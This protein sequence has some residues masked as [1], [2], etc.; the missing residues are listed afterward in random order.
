VSQP[1]GVPF[2]TRLS[3]L[4]SSDP[5]GIG[6]VTVAA[7]GSERTLSW[8]G[9]ESG[10]NRFARELL[11]RGATHGSLI[12]IVI[13]NSRDLVLSVLACW[14]IGAVPITVRWDLPDWERSRLLDAIGPAVV[15]D[16]RSRADFAACAAGHPD[17]ALPL[18]VS[19]MVNG[20]C[21]SGS[22]GLPKVILTTRPAMWTPEQS[23]PFLT[24]WAPVPR[25][26]TIMVPA[27]MYHTNG[28]NTLP[29]LLGGDRLVVLEK[30][31]ASLALSTIER[32]R[33]TN[34][35]ATPTMLARMARVADVDERDLSTVVWILQGAAVMPHSLLHRWF[36]LLSPEKVVMAYG[37]TENFGLAALRGDEWL[38][39]PGSV[40]RGF[41]DTEIRILDSD[42]RPVPTGE[43]GEI[44]LRAP[45]GAT[46][47]YIGG[48]PQLPS[49]PDGFHTG[50]DIGWMDDDGYLYVTDRR[51]D[52]IVTGGANVYPAEV[53][54]ALAE[55]DGIADV[56]V[57][58]LRDPEWG[59][60]VHAVVELADPA[61]QL[62][63]QDVIVYAK[64]KLASYKAPK[65]VEFVAEI[66]RSAA[67]KVSRSAMV[68]ARG[69]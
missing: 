67:T 28:F 13:P 55:H 45:M 54:S 56:V 48:A 6:L 46:Y 61:S 9:L 41:R 36:E 26:Q 25:P 35:T 47:R 3:E 8:Q 16:E 14:K 18:A 40:G 53:E 12:A 11:V 22:T 66:P 20:I 44:Y 19:P 17:D 33:V 38:R 52:M 37:M 64:S 58:G 43:L 29:Y 63:E 15:V 50:G 31:D 57:L 27:P 1:D 65:T 39:H 34:F 4:A 32:H 69:G 62:S 49:T 7:D 2:G 23:E 24:T 60:R 42:G 10:A 51:V 59:R 68:E 5:D 21:S 30:F